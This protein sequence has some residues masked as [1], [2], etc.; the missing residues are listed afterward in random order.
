MDIA[1]KSITIDPKRPINVYVFYNSPNGKHR[2]LLA[3]FRS[4]EI[5]KKRAK[6]IND[7]FRKDKTL[8]DVVESYNAF[9]FKG[10]SW[11]DHMMK[12]RKFLDKITKAFQEG[13]H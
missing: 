2:M 10:V 5:A 12:Y 1:I 13:V 9:K 6:W 7:N 11:E 8:I 3:F 4:K